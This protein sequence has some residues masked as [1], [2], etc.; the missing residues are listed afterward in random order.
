MRKPTKIR[1]SLVLIL[2][3]TALSWPL[4]SNYIPVAVLLTEKESKISLKENWDSGFQ[5]SN[6]LLQFPGIDDD[7]FN[8]KIEVEFRVNT[9]I[10][11][12]I[13]VDQTVPI[14]ISLSQFAFVPSLK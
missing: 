5:S 1:A 4:I 3:L 12:K 8:H 9:K 6:K 10:Y 2:V 13:R 11:N 7:D 14:I